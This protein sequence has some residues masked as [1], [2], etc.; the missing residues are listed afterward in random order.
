MSNQ[1]CLFIHNGIRSRAAALWNVS[2]DALYVYKQLQKGHKSSEWSCT[3]LNSCSFITVT[4]AAFCVYL[5]L[6]LY[7]QCCVVIHFYEWMIGDGLVP[8]MTQPGS[9][10]YSFIN[11]KIHPALCDPL[12]RALYFLDAATDRSQSNAGDVA[13]TH[14]PLY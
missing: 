3:I 6:P 5:G 9:T 2:A 13:Y 10:A 4:A 8:C 7:I 1:H 14:R 11:V 12:T